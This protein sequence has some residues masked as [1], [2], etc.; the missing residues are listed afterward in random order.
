MTAEVT[1]TIPQE[2][3]TDRLE[4][5][6][7]ELEA[8]SDV[9]DPRSRRILARTLAE[10]IERHR[11]ITER[12]L[13]GELSPEVGR[14]VPAVARQIR[15]LARELGVTERKRAS[16]G[17]SGGFMGGEATDGGLAPSASPGGPSARA[18]PAS[19]GPV[20][21]KK[22]GRPRKSARVPERAADLGEDEDDGGDEG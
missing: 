2:S 16:G 9:R 5:L 8:S 1:P 3:P 4:R 11:V 13:R 17:L 18:K 20:A 12:D 7:A 15:D 10:Q 6:A 22:R 19:R 21:K 14:T